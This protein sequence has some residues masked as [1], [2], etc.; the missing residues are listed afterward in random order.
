MSSMKC[1]LLLKLPSAIF[2]ILLTIDPTP[3][4]VQKAKGLSPADAV[5]ILN[6]K[7][8]S[9]KSGGAIWVDVT[10][11]NKSDHVLL[12]Y[13]ELTGVGDDQGGWVYYSDVH[14]NEGRKPQP[15]KF[16]EERGGFGSGGYIHLKPGKTMTDRIN[17][18]K[19]LDLSRPGKY[20]IQ[21]YRRDG[22]GNTTLRSNTITVTVTP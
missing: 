12:V 19:L 21:V 9:V 2:T 13:R 11:E 14:D 3:G 5:L 18:C 10:V 6:A 15:T 7:E 8:S 17:I 22:M 16:L 1:L 20:S 4:Q